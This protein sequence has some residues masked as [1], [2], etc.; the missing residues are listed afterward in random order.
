[1]SYWKK[2]NL[3][4]NMWDIFLS[5]FPKNPAF[6]NALSTFNKNHF[7]VIKRQE[8][9][10]KLK[11]MVQWERR[12]QSKYRITFNWRVIYMLL[13]SDWWLKR[14]SGSLDRKAE[15]TKMFPNHFSNGQMSCASKEDKFFKRNSSNYLLH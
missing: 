13:S 2:K 10:V 3:L 11:S 7:L 15:Q 9:F 5:L 4:Q 12:K 6:D 1:M 14:Y 8:K